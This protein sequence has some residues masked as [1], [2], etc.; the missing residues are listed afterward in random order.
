DAAEF[1][2]GFLLNHL[3]AELL[4]ENGGRRDANTDPITGQAAWY[5][6]RV[7]VERAGHEEAT[8]SAPVFAPFNHPATLMPAPEIVRYGSRR[9][10]G[11]RK[12]GHTG[13]DQVEDARCPISP[14]RFP[15]RRNWGS[16]S[17]STFASG[18]TPAPPPARS[19][20]PAATAPH[21]RTS[22]LTATAPGESGSTAS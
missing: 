19:G 10:N 6:L 13:S 4:P 11:H 2:K 14:P 7:R 1:R 17:T 21:C 9:N 5:D 20:T 15:A 12:N 8:V 16:S 22:T 18:V 3:I